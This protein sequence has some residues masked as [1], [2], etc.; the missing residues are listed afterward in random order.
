MSFTSLQN[1]K[2]KTKRKKFL[3]KLKTSL[4]LLG[5]FLDQFALDALNFLPPLNSDIDAC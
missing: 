3:E 2:I 4:I 1:L 5:E